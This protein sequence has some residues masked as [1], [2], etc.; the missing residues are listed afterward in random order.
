MSALQEDDSGAEARAF[1]DVEDRPEPSLKKD[2]GDE[3][4]GNWFDGPMGDAGLPPGWFEYEADDGTPYFFHPETNTTTWEKPQVRSSSSV[5]SIMTD[6]HVG[7]LL[8]QPV[9]LAAL[10]R[11]ISYTEESDEEPDP[12]E[13][14]HIPSTF[15]YSEASEPGPLSAFTG[16]QLSSLCLT[17]P[18]AAEREG[19]PG[20][21]DSEA[22]ELE[23]DLAVKFARL[24]TDGR[25]TFSRVFVELIQSEQRYIQIL[26][27]IWW[28]A[29][30]CVA[31]KFV[32]VC[33]T[34][35]K[36]RGVVA[37]RQDRVSE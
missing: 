28:A 2:T 25:E 8:A 20:E 27:K 10:E 19:T 32:T 24:S 3:E 35:S 6:E 34:P 14:S 9:G 17:L 13:S 7:S 11:S 16:R 36:S 15:R 1:D 4:E 21:D 12:L 18:W 31:S 23:N 22:Y 33:L 26:D 29:P 5:A 30:C 37:G